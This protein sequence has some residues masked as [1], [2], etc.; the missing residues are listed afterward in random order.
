MISMGAKD[1]GFSSFKTIPPEPR[2]PRRSICAVTVLPTFEPYTTGI[3]CANVIMPALTKPM[4]IIVVAAELCMIPV[5]P[6]PRPQPLSSP[7]PF[8]LLV[9]RV[10]SIFSRLEPASFLRDEPIWLIPKRNRPTPP[11]NPK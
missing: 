4:S 1:D 3:A 11:N 7:T 9:V 5:T 6:S 2:S 8:F 10:W